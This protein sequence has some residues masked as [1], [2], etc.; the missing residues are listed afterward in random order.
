MNINRKEEAKKK[1]FLGNTKKLLEKANDK[2][3]GIIRKPT[4]ADKE[5]TKQL[6]QQL[7]NWRKQFLDLELEQKMRLEQFIGLDAD[8]PSEWRY[9]SEKS[10]GE[11]IS[12]YLD[13]PYDIE[14]TKLLELWKFM[15]THLQQ[16]KTNYSEEERNAIEKKLNEEEIKRSGV[17]QA[18]AITA[19]LS[20]LN[21]D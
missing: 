21:K 17:D 18:F 5:K 10:R 15:N 13:I 7:A 2:L 11:L 19:N 1:L 8:M 20:Q 16:E 9:F 12:P 14:R 6:N 4:R 3:A